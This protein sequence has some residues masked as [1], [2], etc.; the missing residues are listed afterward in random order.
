MVY[1]GSADSTALEA[2]LAVAAQPS[3]ELAPIIDSPTDGSLLPVDPPQRFAW[4]VPGSM[5]A[6]ASEAG[7]EARSGVGYFLLFGDADTPQL[8][9]V[10]TTET[11]YTPDAAAWATISSAGIWTM[12]TVEAATF[13]DDQIAPGG[14]PF[15]GTSV[16]FC[17]MRQP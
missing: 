8:F 15:V 5:A 4:H 7:A 3:S 10:F 9:R 16:L 11:S 13:A 6:L 12:L 14:G 1:Q 17:V 2:L